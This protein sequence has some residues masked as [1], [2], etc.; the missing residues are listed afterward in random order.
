MGEKEVYRVFETPRTV[1]PLS[2]LFSLP[3]SQPQLCF[4]RHLPGQR[5]GTRPYFSIA[6]PSAARSSR[7]RG[8]GGSIPAGGGAIGT[9][10]LAGALA[11]W[12]GGSHTDNRQRPERQPSASVP[13]KNAKRRQARKQANQPTLPPT[14]APAEIIDVKTAAASAAA[15]IGSG[16]WPLFPACGGSGKF[17]QRARGARDGFR[18]SRTSSHTRDREAGVRLANGSFC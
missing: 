18:R 1:C 2:H 7:R 4:L 6:V 14:R 12:V 5:L 3:L 15:K 13:G 9:S 17:G 10:R 8:L 11:Q 16:P